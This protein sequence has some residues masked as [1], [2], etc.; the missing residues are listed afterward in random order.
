MNTGEM[1]SLFRNYVN[2]RPYAEDTQEEAVFWKREDIL[3]YLNRAQVHYNAF[4]NDLD[5]SYNIVLFTILVANLINSSFVL[6]ENCQKI[7]FVRMKTATT[8]DIGYEIKPMNIVE[9][10]R[11]QAFVPYRYYLEGDKVVFFPQ[12]QGSSGQFLETYYLKRLPKLVNDSDI[13]QLPEEIHENIV[14][15]AT[16]N[17]LLR[18]KQGSL[19]NQWAGQ[20]KALDADAANFIKPRITQEPNSVMSRVDWEAGTM[21]YYGY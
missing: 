11:R 14:A 20:V 3:E 4:V 17:G 15:R 1:I 6:P 21:Y 10:N 2:E 8:D 13:C 7:K 18:D 12:F 16:M 5:E 9:I 19:S